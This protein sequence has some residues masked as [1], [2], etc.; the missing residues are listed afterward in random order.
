MDKRRNGTN[1][2]DTFK[3]FRDFFISAPIM[4]KSDFSEA[5]DS[6]FQRMPGPLS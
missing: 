2:K 3:L 1:T 4:F 6:A 5:T